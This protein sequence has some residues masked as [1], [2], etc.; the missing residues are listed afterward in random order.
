MGW[1]EV[2]L[3]QL[4]PVIDVHQLAAQPDFHLL[5]R[6]APVRWHRIQ[7][8]LTLD[9]IGRDGL[10]HCASR[11]FRRA[12]RPRAAGHPAPHPGKPPG[13][14]GGWCHGCA[15][16]PPPDTSAGLRPS[17]GADPWWKSPPLK[18]RSLTYC[19]PRSTWGLSLGFRTR[20][21]SAMK[22][23]HCEYSRKPLVKR[24][25]SGSGPATAGGQLSMTR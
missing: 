24:G 6:R 9:V 7:R 4:A 19:T 5:T 14:S 21:A 25:C 20:A 13:A 23:R 12:R 18:K 22:P 1:R 11:R 15:F 10:W 3:D 8:L 16:R 17:G 2:G